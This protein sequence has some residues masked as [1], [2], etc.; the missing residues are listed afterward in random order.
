MRIS[1]FLTISLC[2]ASHYISHPV[3]S[4]LCHVFSQLVFL[5]VSMYVVPPSLFNRP[6]LLLPETYSL[7]DFAQMWLC[8]CLKQWPKHF[9]LLFSRNVSTCFTCPSFLMSSCLVWSNL[10]F[11]LAH[12]NILISAELSLF[13]SF[14]VTVQHSEVYMSLLV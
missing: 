14:F 2:R 9:N 10:V 7:N 13:S 11:P 5:H 12:L 4:I 1:P 3:F 8:S 6:L